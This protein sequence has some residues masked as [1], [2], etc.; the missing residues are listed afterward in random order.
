MCD[1][2]NSGFHHSTFAIIKILFVLFAFP[3]PM[4]FISEITLPAESGKMYLLPNLLTGLSQEIFHRVPDEN[5]YALKGT[6]SR[7]LW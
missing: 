1:H 7:E 6:V 3:P 5:V 4:A 2:F